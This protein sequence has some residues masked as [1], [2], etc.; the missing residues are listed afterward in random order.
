V[1]WQTPVTDATARDFAKRVHKLFCD[2]PG[3]P[4]KAFQIVCNEM[5]GALSEARPCLL[6]AGGGGPS[7]ILMWNGE[8]VVEV[9]E[10]L[11]RSP[12]FLQPAASDLE[13]HAGALPDRSSQESGVV[14]GMHDSGH[15]EEEEEEDVYKNW[16]PPQKATDFAAHAGQA[17]KAAL[18]RL[19]FNL[20]LR[21]GREIGS[22]HGLDGKG[23]LTPDALHA[24]GIGNYTHLWRKTERRQRRPG[25]V[26]EEAR[27]MLSSPTAT[28][29]SRE[30]VRLA[31]G[32][33]EEAL[34]YRQL[35][36]MA[37]RFQPPYTPRWYEHREALL[38]RGK[39]EIVDEYLRDW[40]DRER[41]RL[42]ESVG[43]QRRRELESACPKHLFELDMRYETMLELDELLL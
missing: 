36:L 14:A 18:K 29:S 32:D 5:S 34:F 27:K 7:S 15:E 33:L 13:Q 4:A 19:K 2:E 9:A 43:V 16:R 30:Q 10:E 42:G 28:A 17:E 31:R 26:V 41:L 35:D 20:L 24:L 6:H 40:D 3:Q 25:K 8:E 11:L 21:D 38:K 39:K 22:S 12:Q 37:H 23:Y 1:C